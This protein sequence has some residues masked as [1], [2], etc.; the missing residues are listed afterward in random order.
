MSEFLPIELSLWKSTVL[1]I[2]YQKATDSSDHVLRNSAWCEEQLICPEWGADIL[3]QAPL[4][5]RV[6]R[7]CFTVTLV[8][9]RSRIL[10]RLG[11]LFCFIFE[12]CVMLKKSHIFF[13]L[14]LSDQ[15]YTVTFH[16]QILSVQSD[17]ILA[18]RTLN[19]LS[20]EVTP[21]TAAKITVVSNIV[22]SHPPLFWDVRT[23][24]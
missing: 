8:P 22:P 12:F 24:P 15:A 20:S 4:A 3:P 23:G 18:Q 7:C 2:W 10:K 11:S 19:I 1:L 16:G 5:A 14:S 6:G 13:M 17:N 21:M 9:R